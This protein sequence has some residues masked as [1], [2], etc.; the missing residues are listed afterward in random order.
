MATVIHHHV[1]LSCLNMQIVAYPNRATTI[2]ILI[3]ISIMTF[4]VIA[5]ALGSVDVFQ[6]TYAICSHHDKDSA[7]PSKV[8][9]VIIVFNITII[10]II[11]AATITAE[12]SALIVSVAGFKHLGVQACHLRLCLNQA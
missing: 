4:K 6:P 3:I 9:L 11:V 7:Q 2:I 10:I 8:L 1:S 12:A 5:I